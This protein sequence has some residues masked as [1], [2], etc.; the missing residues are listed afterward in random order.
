[1]VARRPTVAEREVHDLAE[2][3]FVLKEALRELVRLDQLERSGLAR[4]ADQREDWN[5]AFK[6]A[7][8]ALNED[9]PDDRRA[10]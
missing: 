4:P 7:S 6:R 9:G 3:V 8:D 10:A 2:R 5:K 1:M